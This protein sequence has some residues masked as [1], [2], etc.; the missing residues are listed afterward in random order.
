MNVRQRCVV[1][2]F[3]AILAG[4]ARAHGPRMQDTCPVASRTWWA[5]PWGT[6]PT[7]VR[8]RVFFDADENRIDPA[9]IALQQDDAVVPTDPRLMRSEKLVVVELR[10]LQPLAPGTPY[11]VVGSER[12]RS[13]R[14]LGFETADGPDARAPV[15]AG[16]T[17]TTVVAAPARP[18]SCHTG[19]TYALLDIARPEGDLRDVAYAVWVAGESRIDP[20]TPTFIV[21]AWE[22]HRLIVGGGLSPFPRNLRLPET[23][24]VRLVIAAIDPS[25]NRSVPVEATLDMAA[26]LPEH[27]PWTDDWIVTA[28]RMESL[29]RAGAYDIH[30]PTTSIEELKRSGYAGGRVVLRVCVS[31]TGDVDEI[32]MLNPDPA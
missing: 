1:A 4:C 19:A 5:S 23:G 16:V 10:P 3:V 14:L 7:S 9:S 21:D 22:G 17:K 24:T 12:G 25:G 28:R 18:S 20:D 15:W 31:A 2:G 26:A 13:V 30:L 11:Q 29:R 6:A 8:P 32:T 27:P